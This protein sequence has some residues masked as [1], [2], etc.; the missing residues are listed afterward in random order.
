MS[1]EFRTYRRI[2]NDINHS[3]NSYTYV[4][5]SMLDTVLQLIFSDILNKCFFLYLSDGWSS[6]DILGCYNLT[7]DVKCICCIYLCEN[8]WCTLLLWSY[9]LFCC[10]ATKL[11]RNNSICK[12][13]IYIVDHLR[14]HAINIYFLWSV[15]FMSFDFLQQDYIHKVPA[16]LCDSLCHESHKLHGPCN[17]VT[18][19][20]LP[21][22]QPST[23]SCVAPIA[24]AHWYTCKQLSPLS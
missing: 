10:Q 22:K 24:E 1:R 4:S 18:W 16:I 5:H 8:Q 6:T 17:S 19:L 23:G 7:V 13:C 11:S 2:I 20:Q 14:C 12:N 3:A 9:N 21:C 15:F